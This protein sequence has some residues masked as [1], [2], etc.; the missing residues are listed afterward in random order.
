MARLAWAALAAAIVG[1][2]TTVLALDTVTTQ[3]TS[4]LPKGI[5]VRTFEE[6]VVGSIVKFDAP[7]VFMEKMQESIEHATPDNKA[8][9]QWWY[10]WFSTWPNGFMKHVAARAGDHV[11][12]N[13]EGYFVRGERV[14]GTVEPGKWRGCRT[15]G[16]GEMAVVGEGESIDTRVFGP[17][18]EH[19]VRTYR[20]LYRFQG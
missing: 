5:Y 11:C 13:D 12:V 16:S 20:L 15:L 7:P 1:S 8:G 6:P 19:R 10:D 14:G 17:I 2:I 4:S 18:P 9:L 3:R